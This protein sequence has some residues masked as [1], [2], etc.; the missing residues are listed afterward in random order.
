[1]LFWKLFDFSLPFP[2]LLTNQTCAFNTTRVCSGSVIKANAGCP[3]TD[4]MQ[5]RHC[6]GSRSAW[7]NALPI[8][9]QPNLISAG[10]GDVDSLG[11]ARIYLI[12]DA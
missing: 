9:R 6:P 7:D 8:W 2:C 1:M 10:S 4:K 5:L 11:R 3:I 12:S